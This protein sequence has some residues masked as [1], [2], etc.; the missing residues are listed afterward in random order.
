MASGGHAATYFA[1][2]HDNGS[3]ALWNLRSATLAVVVG[4]PQV[5]DPQGDVGVS[6][7]YIDADAN[8]AY[9]PS[10]VQFA[11]GV[12]GMANVLDAAIGGWSAARIASGHGES[13]PH[14]ADR[15]GAIWR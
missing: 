1:I 12:A 4:A 5:G 9:G 6:F 10:N 7:S 2:D 3:C 15:I 14:G 13:L 8:S 11:A